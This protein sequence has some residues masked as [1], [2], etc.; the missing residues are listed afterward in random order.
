MQY[1]VFTGSGAITT[2]RSQVMGWAINCSSAGTINIKDG[3]SGDVVV[4]LSMATSDN[5]VS[6]ADGIPFNDT[7]YVE[8]ASG[9]F[10]GSIWVE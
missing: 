5:N 4:K 7:V 9:T 10:S 1:K 3:S 6:S 8:V 2:G